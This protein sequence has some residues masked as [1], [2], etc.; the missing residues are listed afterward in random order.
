MFDDFDS[1]TK[2]IVSLQ[3][4]NRIPQNRSIEY[5]IIQLQINVKSFKI[6]LFIF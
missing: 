4:F 2:I 1:Y 5:F 3:V 6:E